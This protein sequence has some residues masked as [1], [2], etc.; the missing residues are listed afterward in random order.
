MFEICD[1]TTKDTEGTEGLMAPFFFSVPSVCSV[2]NA[3]LSC[4]CAAAR[5]GLCYADRTSSSGVAQWAAT[6]VATEPSTAWRNAPWPCEPITS[7][8]SFFFLA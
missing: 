7:T 2:V 3:A 4:D 8:S 5:R 1:S 6:R